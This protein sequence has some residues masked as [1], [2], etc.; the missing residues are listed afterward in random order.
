MRNYLAFFLGVTLV[1][2]GFLAYSQRENIVAVGSDMTGSVWFLNTSQQIQAGLSTWGLRIPSLSSAGDCLVTDASGIVSAAPCG[3]GGSSKWESVGGFLQPLVAYVN[4]SIRGTTFTATSTTASSTFPN[5]KTNKIQANTSA[6]V[7]FFSSNGTPVSD[8]GVGA[9][10][11][12][13]F[14][15]GVNIDGQTRIATSI[16]GMVKAAAGVLSAAVAGTDYLATTSPWTVGNAAFVASNGLISSV[17]T[18]TLTESVTGLSLSDSTRGLFGGSAALSLDTGYTIPLTS[19]L[20]TASASTTG[21]IAFWSGNQTLGN[22]ATG[23]LTESVTGLSYSGTPRVLNTASILSLDTGY[24]IPLTNTLLTASASSTG[25]LAFWSGNQTIGNVATGTLTETVTGLQFDQTRSL[26]GGS[27]I[28]S[29]T[30]GFTIPTTTL[31]TLVADYYQSPASRIS[32]G[33]GL[34]WTSTT[35]NSSSTPAFNIA[36]T[37]LDGNG[38][39]FSSATATFHIRNVPNATTLTSW[40]CKASSTGSVMVQFGDGTNWTNAGSCST[41]GARITASTN[42]TFTADED[43][44]V[45][46]GSSATNP[47]RVT[48]T[49]SINNF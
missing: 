5:L 37:T 49:T 8:L 34:G 35:I 12:T 15:G 47:S 30:A 2:G 46:I 16:T 27:A 25:N 7:L 14:F 48:I 45:R 29:L 11:N 26:I 13:S 10:A 38:R 24:T 18:G 31:W 42:N 44:M 20:L 6:G 17:A 21:N 32:L 39:Q 43:F 33:A 3:G 28:L 19:S 22:I 36:S 23:T 41:T 9:S 40:Y 4:D 1:I